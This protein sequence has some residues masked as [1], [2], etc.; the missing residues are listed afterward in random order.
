ML[1]SMHTKTRVIF[2]PQIMI[3]HHLTQDKDAVS[4]VIHGVAS[5]EYPGPQEYCPTALE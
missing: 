3:Q 5:K 2:I 4:T 1:L